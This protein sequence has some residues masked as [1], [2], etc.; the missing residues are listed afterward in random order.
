MRIAILTLAMLVLAIGAIPLATTDFVARMKAT[1]AKDADDLSLMRTATDAAAPQ[2]NGAH[3]IAARV[4]SPSTAPAR[5]RTLTAPNAAATPKSHEPVPAR[6]PATLELVTLPRSPGAAAPPAR[7]ISREEAIAAVMGSRE[8]QDTVS[9]LARLYHATFGRFPDYEGINYYTGQR[10]DGRP[11]GAI[12]DEFAG[13]REFEMRYGELDDAEFVARILANVLG[14]ASQADVRAYWTAE[15]EAGRMTRGQV[16]VDLAESGA[17]RERSA[18]QVF[19]SIAYIEILR[20]TPDPAGY[21][22]WVAQLRA[23]QPRD[24]VING[25]LRSP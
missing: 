19:V 6:L 12:A 21:N 15:L 11:L 18:H 4:A 8:F 22:Y 16:I 3:A 9:P 7:K 10:E 17:F 20:R 13:S 14:N 1:A 25:L 24:N 2:R 5:L 23:G